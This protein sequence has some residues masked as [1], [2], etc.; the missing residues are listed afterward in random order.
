A[1]GGAGGSLLQRRLG[2]LPV[3]ED[4][5]HR[6]IAGLA[7]ELGGVEYVI[8]ADEAA[9]RPAPRFVSGEPVA[10]RFSACHMRL[11]PDA[12]NV[13]GDKTAIPDNWQ[14]RL[15]HAAAAMALSSRRR[16]D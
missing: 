15:A 12:Q 8:P 16:G 14:G 6:G 5:H 7:G 4:A 10:S 1:F 11:L 9:P 2:G 3:G 13:A